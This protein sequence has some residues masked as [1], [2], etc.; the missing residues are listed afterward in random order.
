MA[1]DAGHGVF[2]TLC[3]DVIGACEILLSLCNCCQGQDLPA[4]RMEAGAE[5]A[6]PLTA[7]ERAA[8]YLF[9]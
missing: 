1:G 2:H 8:R 4:A 6:T 7:K 3:S 5:Q 9:F